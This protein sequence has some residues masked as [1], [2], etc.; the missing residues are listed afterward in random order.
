MSLSFSKVWPKKHPGTHFL[1][2]CDVLLLLFLPSGFVLHPD[3][4]LC[5]LTSEED[6]C[7][8]PTLLYQHT[9]CLYLFSLFPVCFAVLW[10]V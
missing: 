5:H 3:L 2:L 1:C 9:F 7:P 4:F 10:M 6:S 8:R